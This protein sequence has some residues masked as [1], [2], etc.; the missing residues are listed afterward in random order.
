MTETHFKAL[1]GALALLFA[2][3]GIFKRGH[4]YSWW[5]AAGSAAVAALSVHYDSFW[6]I[7]VGSLAMVWAF[8]C[9]FDTID[10]GWRARAGMTAAVALGAFVCVW[11]TLENIS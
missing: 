8:I 6:M 3:A 7:V 1:F 11:P 5:T 4:R 9:T 2:V 10:L